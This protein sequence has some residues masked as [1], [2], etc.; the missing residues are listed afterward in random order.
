M[1]M[2]SVFD[3]V[4]FAELL[5]TLEAVTVRMRVFV[6]FT[7]ADGRDLDSEGDLDFDSVAL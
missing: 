2:V 4:T 1:V 7:V 5:A 6:S 3:T